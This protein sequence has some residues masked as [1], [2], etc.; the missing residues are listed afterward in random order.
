MNFVSIIVVK[1]FLTTG[2]PAPFTLI[3]GKIL[4]KEAAYS[5]SSCADRALLLVK[6]A[7][8][9]KPFYAVISKCNQIWKV[10]LK[11]QQQQIIGETTFTNA[12]GIEFE[13]GLL[14]R[15]DVKN[16]V[17]LFL[18][19]E[20]SIELSKWNSIASDANKL[21]FNFQNRYYF[22]NISY[23][24]KN[25]NDLFSIVSNHVHWIKWS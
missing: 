23:H 10:F 5:V 16:I 20:S 22:L 11:E 21:V 2:L 13:S 17:K 7:E 15:V 9:S 19:K 3:E 18:L 8:S 24:K 1:I 12:L 25:G 4:E 14:F 6:T